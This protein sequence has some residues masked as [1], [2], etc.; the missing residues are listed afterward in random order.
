MNRLAAL[1]LFPILPLSG[2]YAARQTGAVV[3][4]ED[5]RNQT[6]VT[7]TPA[8]G[9]LAIEI[10]VKGIDILRSNWNSV[11]DFLAKPTSTGVSYKGPWFNRLDE[12]AFWANGKKYVF[13]DG[14]GNIRGAQAM[15]G[16]PMIDPVNQWR[17]VEFKADARAAW[18]TSKLDF[19]RHPDWMAQWPF[20][21]TVEVTYR[22]ENGVLEVRTRVE[23]LSLEP[24]PVAFG[25]EPG[26]RLTDAPRDEWTLGIGARGTWL[27]TPAKIP[28][29]EVRT[30]EEVYG[31]RQNLALKGLDL[32]NQFAD[33]ERDA[34]GRCLFWMQGKK[35]RIELVLGPLWQAMGIYAPPP[36]SP[37][38]GFV[39][40][41]PAAS[42]TNGMNL[43]HRGVY[44]ELQSIPPGGTW[45]ESFWIRPSGF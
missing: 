15:S 37:M 38:S 7:V 11:D 6:V 22:L 13:N 29:G 36:S 3:Q 41:E 34:A 8:I 31:T 40:L 43:A 17:L 25:F 42:V 30:V 14:L 26:F 21:H 1:A 32:D 19:Y 44:K 39:N 24:M 2:Q 12:H 20:A 33:F 45:E 23:N 35:Q 10:R 9:A 27:L 28:T 5:V 16:F 18:V 4:L